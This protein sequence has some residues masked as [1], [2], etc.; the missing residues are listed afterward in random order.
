MVGR[1]TTRSSRYPWTR[2]EEIKHAYLK[3]AKAIHPDRAPGADRFFP[4]VREAYAVLNDPTRRRAYDAELH[5][6]RP[7]PAT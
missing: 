4:L 2:P 6:Q 7:E 5:G 3:A 1:R